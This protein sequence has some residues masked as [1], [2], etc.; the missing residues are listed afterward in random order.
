MRA[1]GAVVGIDMG[2]RHF[3]TTSD[4]THVPNPRHLA[5]SADRLATAQRSVASK[6]RGSKRHGEAAARVGN[7]HRKIRR[8]RLDYTHKVALSLVRDHD[9]I[10]H[11]ALTVANMS[12]RP[13]PRPVGDGTYAPNG[14]AAKTGLNKAILDAG[15][16]VFLKILRD[17]AESAGRAVIEVNPRNTSRRCAE[18]GHVAEENRKDEQFRCVTC[19]HEAHAD[20]NAAVNILRAG[21]ALRAAQAA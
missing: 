2:V 17:K 16:G 21:L 7:V 18:C 6:K 14:A 13:A 1:T 15:W 3:L 4:G 12:K 9:V 20:V 11:E 10:V 5:A 8:Q 19:G